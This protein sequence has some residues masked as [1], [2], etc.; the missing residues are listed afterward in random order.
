MAEQY[1]NYGVCARC[2]AGI[3]NIVEI[4]GKTYGTECAT[5]ILGIREMP[6]WF[7]GGSWEKAKE[8]W[9]KEQAK[10][11]EEEKLRKAKDVELWDDIVLF[12]ALE[13]EARKA[14][15]G[16]GDWDS[17]F[18]ES[19][20]HQAGIHIHPSIGLNRW[21]TRDEAEKEWSRADGSFFNFTWLDSKGLSGLSAK[22]R[23]I[24]EKL[25]R[26]YNL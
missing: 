3:K 15:Q 25:R 19:T 20:A 1:D 16:Q 21:K 2:G 26:K 18:I 6:A 12:S 14:T 22:Q 4:G 7:N 10:R 17:A 11:E 9:E 5:V 24:I 8:K 13:Y 23:A